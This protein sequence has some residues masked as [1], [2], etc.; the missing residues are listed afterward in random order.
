MT[1]VS[2]VVPTYNRISLL[3]ETV[4]SVKAQSHLRWELLVVDDGSCDGTPAWVL[5]QHQ[6]DLRIRLIQ[7]AVH[8][9]D[10]CGAQVCRN[11]GRQMGYGEVLVFLDSDDLLAPDCLQ[12][13][14]AFLNAD[15]SL[16]AVVGQALHF[17]E[18]PGDLGTDRI[19]GRWQPGQD[20][21]DFFLADAIPWQTSGPLWRR[22]SLE[23]VGPWD[24]SLQHV[25]HDH[26]FHVRALCR[27]LKIARVERV[28]Y[29]WRVP[30]EDSLSSLESF[31]TRHRDGGM[32]RAYQ[33]ILHQVVKSGS[34][35]PLRRR[36]MVAESIRLAVRCRNFGGSA[37]M[38]EQ[39]LLD[40]CNAHLIDRGT[41]TVCR[42]LLRCWWRLG[43]ILPSM[44]LLNRLASRIS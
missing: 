1:L 6:Q 5:S 21:L 34:L 20:D 37:S 29:Y 35:T 11:L 14:L 24:E 22:E 2:V 43:G 4:L 16:D 23:R 19:W 42:V 27:G 12:N 38:A 36:L 10:A 44:A 39:I 33:A 7:R 40:A 28:D 18:Q 32:I 3:K 25:G 41:T 15:P 9:P 17:S 31:K 8:R 26:E 30:R 13:R